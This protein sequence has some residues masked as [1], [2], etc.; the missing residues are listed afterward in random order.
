M[1]K[2]SRMDINAV[3]VCTSQLPQKSHERIYR[4]LEQGF[5][6]NNLREFSSQ[7]GAFRHIKYN[8]TFIDKCGFALWWD[9]DNI[10]F[11]EYILIEELFRHQGI[12]STIID[13]IK[14]EGKMIV[15]EV[16]QGS[17]TIGFYQIN[18]FVCNK[19]NYNP[20]HINNYVPPKY[21]LMSY[22]RELLP[23]EYQDFINTISNKELQF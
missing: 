19:V 18:G 16:E 12:G 13:S 14:K 15:L 4:K 2:N 23:E 11:V 9:F 5:G 22:N 20:I 21:M 3:T 1:Y 6:K 7:L 10:I 17:E 8:I